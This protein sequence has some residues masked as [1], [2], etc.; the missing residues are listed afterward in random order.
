MRDEVLELL[1]KHQE[2]L[3]LDSQKIHLENDLTETNKPQNE[4]NTERQDAS[5]SR[6]DNEIESAV[7]LD[8][9]VGRKLELEDGS[10]KGTL[11]N[12]PENQKTM[13]TV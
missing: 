9:S 13:S 7:V 1:N 8:I 10:S 12:G 3:P 5:R 2:S 6:I 4:N 11:S